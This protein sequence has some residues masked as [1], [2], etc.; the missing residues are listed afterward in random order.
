MVEKKLLITNVSCCLHM[1]SLPE[2]P[3]FSIPGPSVRLKTESSGISLAPLLIAIIITEI[4][5][6]LVKRVLNRS[7]LFGA[8]QL[9][10]FVKET[11]NSWI[12]FDVSIF[13][14]TRR[15]PFW[16]FLINDPFSFGILNSRYSLLFST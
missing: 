2:D 5:L 3:V 10:E 11:Y 14:F 1:N 12:C 7:D 9:F 8:I 16:K 4:Y 6:I 15:F 13:C